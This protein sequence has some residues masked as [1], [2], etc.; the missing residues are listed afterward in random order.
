[1]FHLTEDEDIVSS[2]FIQFISEDDGSRFFKKRTGWTESRLWSPKTGTRTRFLFRELGTI[3]GSRFQEPN[4]KLTPLMDTSRAGCQ[5][6][7]VPVGPVPVGLVYRVRTVQF[8]SPTG[9]H[10]ICPKWKLIA[11]DEASTRDS[12]FDQSDW[13][14]SRTGLCY[15][16]VTSR[17]GLKSDW[18]QVGLDTQLYQPQ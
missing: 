4:T 14:S 8:P 10:I 5:W 17:T 15:W 6:N 11:S 7:W 16:L 1:M 12:T 13:A 18:S 9:F 3:S 2:V